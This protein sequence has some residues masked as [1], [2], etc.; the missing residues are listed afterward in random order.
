M[1]LGYVL[2]SLVYMQLPTFP[3]PSCFVED[4]LSIGVWACFWTL[5]SVS[6]IH[7]SVFIYCFDYYSFVVLSEAWES[8]TSC[9]FFFQ[10]AL[11]I[12]SL[13]WFNINFRII[14]FGP[15]KNVMGNLLGITL[16]L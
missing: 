1:V 15:V 9:L 8:Y 2:T 7:M 6:L 12:L 14:C 16:N 10:V 11:A 4:Y 3:T 5:Y 13:S